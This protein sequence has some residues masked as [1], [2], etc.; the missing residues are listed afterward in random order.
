MR[1]YCLLIAAILI[2]TAL[3]ADY[4][5]TSRSANVKEEP[6]GSAATREHVEAGVRLE[7]LD[8]GLQTHEYYHVQTQAGT[9]GWIYRTLVRRYKEGGRQFTVHDFHHN[10]D[11]QRGC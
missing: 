10:L 11:T 9:V 2:S 6:L 8:D 5:I 4:L 1:A 7:L 3:R